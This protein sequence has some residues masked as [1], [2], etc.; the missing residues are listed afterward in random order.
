VHPDRYFFTFKDEVLFNWI[1]DAFATSFAI[2]P[3]N[4][5]KSEYKLTNDLIK[6]NV[7][8]YWDAQYR[9]NFEADFEKM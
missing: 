2:D 6:K 8:D 1:E 5:I 4:V 3:N 9:T 7:D